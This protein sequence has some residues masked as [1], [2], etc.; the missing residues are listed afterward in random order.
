MASAGEGGDLD[1][2]FAVPNNHPMEPFAGIEAFLQVVETG[3]F[4]AAANALQTAKSS[5]SETVRALEDRLGVRLLDR[6]TRRVRM[7]EAGER[8]Y[9]R[10][11]RLVDDA[12][13]ARDEARQSQA[14]PAGKLR[15]SAPQ[16]FGR[17]FIVPTIQGFL[18]RHPRVE[19]ELRE[20]AAAIS[21]VEAGVDLAIRIAERPD[22]T[23]VVRRLGTS[24]VIVVASPGYLAHAGAPTRPGDVARHAFVGFAPLAWRDRWRIGDEEIRIRP[25]LVTDSSE[26]LRS[27][28]I[29]GLG[30]V[31]LPDWMVGDAIA[32]GQLVRVLAE[33]P[34]PESGVYAVHPSRRLIPA[35]VRA[36]VDLLAHDLR[37]RGIAA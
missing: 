4:T 28:A 19:V 32:A 34:A 30:L 8:F 17:R 1:R 29:A 16:A 31:A 18:G 6:T 13:A 25:V 10:C 22:E 9:A 20:S 12:N 2:L 7:T 14:V 26:S 23:L 35:S 33:H 36:F 27:A 5:V 24:R 21:L 15:L 11:R 37:A 3:S